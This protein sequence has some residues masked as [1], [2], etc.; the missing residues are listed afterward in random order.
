M[1]L[2]DETP[3]EIVVVDTDDA[4]L[5]MGTPSDRRRRPGRLL[6][7]VA[8]IAAAVVA[9]ALVVQ[10]LADREDVPPVDVD[11][12]ST[13]TSTTTTVAPDEDAGPTATG[14][15]A[16][17]PVDGETPEIQL[18][19][20]IV[21]ADPVQW[22]G[23][24]FAAVTG[25]MF[26]GSGG[27]Q[28]SSD[29]RTWQP[30]ELPEW[31]G[32]N[33]RSGDEN[34]LVAWGT[35]TRSGAPV[36]AHFSGPDEVALVDLGDIEPDPHPSPYVTYQ[37]S[38]N[39]AAVSGD[40]IMV[41]A[42]HRSE[43]DL[44]ATP[45]GA[46]IAADWL[47][48][49][50]PDGQPVVVACGPTEVPGCDPT[51]EYELGD[52]GIDA[53]GITQFGDIA[54]Y[55]FEDD[56]VERVPVDTAQSLT[57]TQAPR[58]FAAIRTRDGSVGATAP[59]DYVPPDYDLLTSADGVEWA[60]HPFP[61]D[62]F[63]L[64]AT[65][66][67]FLALAVGTGGAIRSADG[68][69]WEPVEADTPATITDVTGGPGG[70]LFIGQLPPEDPVPAVDRIERAGYVITFDFMDG[71]VITD[72]GGEVLHTNTDNTRI[73]L[74]EGECPVAFEATDTAT[75]EVLFELS[76]DDVQAITPVRPG[77]AGPTDSGVVL[78]WAPTGGDVEWVR[79][80][81]MIDVGE[82]QVTGATFALGDG[83]IFAQVRAAGPGRAVS[84]TDPFGPPPGPCEATVWSL[85]EEQVEYF[86][87]EL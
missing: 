10:L 51:G 21:G 37:T 7:A 44:G 72:S 71:V 75:G 5:E 24:R 70:A 49:D 6:A 17:S 45:T 42:R 39:S 33:G 54:V 12:P 25:D 82:R 15:L 11:T 50:W 84:L 78:A 64:T 65:D 16:W 19:P 57:L 36:L 20:G 61:G 35:D 29:G 58:G 67:E 68:I 13:T 80:Q 52:F 8:A 53:R 77:S 60:A 9:L 86:T 23:G 66:D 73:D 56:H 85:G 30:A 55:R 79:L 81:E 32:V 31:F 14:D 41:V 2:A 74:V 3:A 1:L 4:V 69:T 38:I 47:Y 59:E 18:D 34:G 87:I 40:T 46:D 22:A 48:L 26:N 43:V 62:S 27:L 83:V 63:T 28:F 76:H